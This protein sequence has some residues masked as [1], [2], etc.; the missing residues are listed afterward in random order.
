MRVWL[1]R[2]SGRGNVGWLRPPT[3]WQAAV[4]G[5][6]RPADRRRMP[7]LAKRKQRTLIRGGT[8]RIVTTRGGSVAGNCAVQVIGRQR[9][10]AAF[11]P[12]VRISVV[13]DQLP[14]P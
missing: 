12:V 9:R 13:T 4:T 5:R 7:G 11:H 3:A 6:V 1:S 14:R 10:N 8:K 2:A